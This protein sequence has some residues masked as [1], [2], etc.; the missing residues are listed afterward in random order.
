M[1]EA[2]AE[3]SHKE[4]NHQNQ[5]CGLLMPHCF[6]WRLEVAFIKLAFIVRESKY[7]LI[8]RRSCLLLVLRQQYRSQ[9]FG[10]L[11]VRTCSHIRISID[12]S[13]LDVDNRVQGWINELYEIYVF[14]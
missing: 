9:R 14:F 5:K 4:G 11:C 2:V 8:M 12:R 10:V 7:V 1:M 6:V 3:T 13:T